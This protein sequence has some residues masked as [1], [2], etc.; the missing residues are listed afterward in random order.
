MFFFGLESIYSERVYSSGIFILK[1]IF[2][3]FALYFIRYLFQRRLF[4]SRL[5]KDL[6]S[7]SPT[8]DRWPASSVICRSAS[9]ILRTLHHKWRVGINISHATR[10]PEFPKPISRIRIVTRLLNY[11]QTVVHGA[12]VCM[13]RV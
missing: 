13:E 12:N 2:F 4:L 1:L 9:D 8:D 10:Q 11:S 7:S 6:P 5:I 3:S